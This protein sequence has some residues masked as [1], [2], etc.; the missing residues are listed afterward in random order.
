MLSD[1]YKRQ[2][3]VLC[4]EG[5]VIDDYMRTLSPRSE[6]MRSISSASRIKA[7]HDQIVDAD[8][9][10]SK[11]RI[12]QELWWSDAYGL[13]LPR[14]LETSA[15]WIALRDGLKQL[16][17]WSGPGRS[18]RKAIDEAIFYLDIKE[19]LL[20][21]SESE[22]SCDEEAINFIE[23]C[24]DDTGKF[25][26]TRRA[27][28]VTMR[29]YIA[30]GAIKSELTW[31]DV[32]GRSSLFFTW[33]ASKLANLTET[34]TGAKCFRKNEN[35]CIGLCGRDAK[36]EVIQAAI[37]KD[38]ETRRRV[39]ESAKR[40]RLRDSHMAKVNGRY[41]KQ[42]A[43]LMF[44]PD[45]RTNK[46][47]PDILYLPNNEG[48]GYLDRGY[49]GTREACEVLG[50]DCLSN[51]DDM[52]L[53]SDVV[54]RYRALKIEWHPDKHLNDVDYATERF[55]EIGV[56]FDRL[57]QLKEERPWEGKYLPYGELY[58]DISSRYSDWKPTA[59]DFY[60]YRFSPQDRPMP[61]REYMIYVLDIECRS[62]FGRVNYFK[63]E[64]QQKRAD[65]LKSSLESQL[66]GGQRFA[67]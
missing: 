61:E 48:F 35:Y 24:L 11:K 42:M 6:V 58:K 13:D 55:K 36:W 28:L 23:T 37:A 4:D 20:S 22:D 21:L 29:D 10:M 1:E 25:S 34:L 8:I 50:I 62:F 64:I 57:K 40:R 2:I 17:W 67:T 5:S 43:K 18:Q 65:S 60:S 38:E 47:D 3:S 39:N 49:H 54:K 66:S 31:S 9:P 7:D 59:Y 45:E 26:V 53:W 41:R 63:E 32:R 51:L 44:Y 16:S 52:L 27:Q 56:A 30:T 15:D 33:F 12:A 19:R 46:P 14:P